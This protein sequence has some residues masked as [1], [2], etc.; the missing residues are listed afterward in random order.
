MNEI[1]IIVFCVFVVFVIFVSGFF[2]GKNRD[3][4]RGMESAQKDCKRARDKLREQTDYIERIEEREREDFARIG[5][6][7]RIESEDSERFRELQRIFD[8]VE[9]RNQI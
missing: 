9:K 3:D 4:K 2:F 6:L 5:E 8:T 1:K 7:E